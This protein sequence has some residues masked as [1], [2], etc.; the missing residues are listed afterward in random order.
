M[1]GGPSVTVSRICPVVR[2]GVER[3]REKSAGEVNHRRAFCHQVGKASLSRGVR[4]SDPS[5]TNYGFNA[6][7]VGRKS[8]GG[9]AVRSAAVLS[10]LRVRIR[11]QYSHID[12][13]R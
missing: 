10:H 5:C 3:Q 9:V 2:Q 11:L 12:V 7:P 13:T 6:P 1:L 4:F 8:N